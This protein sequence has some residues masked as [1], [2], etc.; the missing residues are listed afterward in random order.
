MLFRSR[1]TTVGD[2][3]ASGSYL[4]AGTESRLWR[5]PLSEMITGVENQANHLPT[6]FGLEQNYPNPFNPS[7]NIKFQIP[8]TSFVTLKVFDLLG[9]EVATLVNEEMSPG[10]YERVF[11][12]K[13]GSA[14]GGD[15]SWLA[16]GVYLYRLQA[17]DFVSVRKMLV[18]K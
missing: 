13:G 4:F 1:S 2:L 8:S 9:R 7:T 12:A 14:S 16:S 3:T 6:E 5:R 17:A 15:A 11:S 10:S 18:V